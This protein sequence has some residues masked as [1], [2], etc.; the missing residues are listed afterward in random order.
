MGDQGQPFAAH[1]PRWT[2]RLRR[3]IEERSAITTAFSFF[4]KRTKGQQQMP[5][6]FSELCVS[7]SAVEK[8]FRLR[9]S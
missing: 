2:V 3:Q 8:G 5:Q 1:P 7:C 6:L 4:R 9:Q